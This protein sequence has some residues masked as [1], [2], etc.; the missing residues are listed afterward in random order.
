MRTDSA[1]II[2]MQVVEFARSRHYQQWLKALK[3]ARL[4]VTLQP[5]YQFHVVVGG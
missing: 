2:L 5:Y 3:T 1:I 4:K